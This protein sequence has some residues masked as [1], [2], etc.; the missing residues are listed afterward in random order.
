VGNFEDANHF[1]YLLDLQLPPQ[2]NASECEDVRHWVLRK[3]KCM[4][5]TVANGDCAFDVQALRLGL[6]RSP[7]TWTELRHLVAEWTREAAGTA[8][9][10]KVYAWSGELPAALDEHN[11]ST[12]A[13]FLVRVGYKLRWSKPRRFAATTSAKPGDAVALGA[14]SE[15]QAHVLAQGKASASERSQLDADGTAKVQCK[16]ESET[17]ECL[18]AIAW[19]IGC[20]CRP[21]ESPPQLAA[22][23]LRQA[24]PSDVAL[25]LRGYRSYRGAEDAS[26][27]KTAKVST[28]HYKLS[29]IAY[30][31]QIG[32]KK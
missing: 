18:R 29:S 7:A 30:M 19:S 17:D 32:K 4:V 11:P 6:E 8:M 20:P 16:L 10:R 21:E 24:D 1:V 28:R 5:P 26:E 14:K 23:T 25:M 22:D 12:R 13:K 27:P 3:G 2:C 9:W 15:A 31:R